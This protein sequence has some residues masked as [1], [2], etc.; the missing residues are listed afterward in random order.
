[1]TAHTWDDE[2]EARIVHGAN[3]V[4]LLTCRDCHVMR[5]HVPE[6][7]LLVFLTA[8]GATR[9]E[10][11]ECWSYEIAKDHFGSV[12]TKEA[13]DGLLT[14]V[15]NPGQSLLR[16]V[17]ALDVDATIWRRTPMQ[18]AHVAPRILR[19]LFGP[20]SPHAPRALARFWASR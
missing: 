12:P 11:S 16:A 7:S 18:R 15:A 1:V 4:A 9:W 19:A 8:A 5:V 3:T 10:P 2:D 17:V 14:V 20:P 13:P 6:L